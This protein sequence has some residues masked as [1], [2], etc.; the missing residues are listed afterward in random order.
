MYIHIVV[1]CKAQTTILNISLPLHNVTVIMQLGA[2]L[3][4]S[5]GKA[6]AE[7]VFSHTQI[8]SLKLGQ[9]TKHSE[10]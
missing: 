10:Y 2:D 7:G 3:L 6:D 4:T 1:L 5:G 8:I 9:M